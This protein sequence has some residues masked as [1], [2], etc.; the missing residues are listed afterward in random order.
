MYHVRHIFYL[1]VIILYR[2]FS[3]PS[4]RSLLSRIGENDMKQVQLVFQSIDKNHDGEL[5]LNELEE[6]AKELG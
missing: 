5:S 2:P 1:H 3:M 4:Y 6:F